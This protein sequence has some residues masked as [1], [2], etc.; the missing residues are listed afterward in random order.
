MGRGGDR[1]MAR[2]G[3][4][5]KGLPTKG[6]VFTTGE[7]KRVELGKYYFFTKLNAHSPPLPQR[8]AP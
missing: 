5:G 6:E 8:Y 4:G 1:E 7:K 2:G 3:D